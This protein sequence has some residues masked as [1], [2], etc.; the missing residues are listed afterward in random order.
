[1]GTLIA[2]MVCDRFY[3]GVH[4]LENRQNPLGACIKSQSTPQSVEAKPRC[5]GVMDR[6]A[7]SAE[8]TQVRR[9]LIP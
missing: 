5:P 7:V 4:G 2:S 3:P 9:D 6:W 1:M 8:A